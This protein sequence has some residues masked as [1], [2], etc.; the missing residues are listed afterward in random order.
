VQVGVDI[1]VILFVLA[2]SQGLIRNCVYTY[3]CVCMCGRVSLLKK[4][5]SIALVLL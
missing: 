2:I 4:R 1:L 3:V 5:A